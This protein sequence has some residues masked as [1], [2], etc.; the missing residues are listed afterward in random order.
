MTDELTTAQRCQK[1]NS[2]P[3]TDNWAPDG[4]MGY[5]HGAYARWCHRCVVEAQLDHAR[6]AA[7]R[8][9]ALER[10]LEGLS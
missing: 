3:A 7:K 1:C 9:P 10:K 4:V 8:I 5:I 6:D 2:R